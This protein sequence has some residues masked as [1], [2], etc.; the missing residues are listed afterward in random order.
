MVISV[1]NESFGICRLESG[2]KVP[3]WLKQEEGPFYSLTRTSEEL[4]IVCPVEWIPDGIEAER[5]WRCLK[6][7]GPLDFGEVGILLSLA[8]PLADVDVSIFALSTY[9]TDYL[10]LKEKD[11]DRAI[12]ALERA[13]HEIEFE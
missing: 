9:D 11:F 8:K 3:K 5:G 2:N 6:V 7:E 4:S 1:L 12:K 13:G 10:L